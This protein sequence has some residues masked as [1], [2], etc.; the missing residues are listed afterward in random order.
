MRGLVV[1]VV[2]VVLAGC[3]DGDWDNAMSY[4]PI[5]QGKRVASADV[6]PNETPP[7]QAVETASLPSPVRDDPTAAMPPPRARV[8]EPM[9]S[10][11]PST[12][13]QTTVIQTR[14]PMVVADRAP[15]SDTH[16]RI[17]ATQRATDGGY[18]GMDEDAQKVEYD[19]T[20]ADCVA[21]D[22]EHGMVR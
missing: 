1:L 8:A 9:A 11:A 7:P 6:P 2:C 3:S 13:V 15:I 20:Y 18:M 5:E 19:R 4:L 16:C 12:V 21:W 17:V 14:Q 10:S 22:V